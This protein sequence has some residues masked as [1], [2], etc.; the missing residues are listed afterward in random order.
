MG[1]AAR[2][3]LLGGFLL[4]AVGFSA[5]SVEAIIIRHDREDRTHHADPADFPFLA[6]V[7]V[8][9]GTLIA[10]DW[11]LT[12]AHVANG[13]SPVSGVVMVRGKT[14]NVLRIVYHPSWV[15]DLPEGFAEPSWVDLALLQLAEPISDVEPVALY[16]GKDEKGRTVT[17]VGRGKT[18]DGRGGPHR[19]DR[20]LR[21]AENEVTKAE[22][23]LLYFRFNRP[24]EGLNR[25]GIGG[26]GD[27]G[28]PALTRT[29]DKLFIVGVCFRNDGQGRGDAEF[30][31]GTH[32]VYTRVSTNMDWIREVMGTGRRGPDWQNLDRDPMPGHDAAAAATAFFEA[33]KRGNRDGFIAFENR[34]RTKEGLYALSAETRADTWMRQASRW[35][36]LTPQRWLQVTPGR[37]VV[38]AESNGQ[39]RSLSFEMQGPAPRKVREIHIAR[40]SSPAD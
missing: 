31:Y 35:K 9:H 11:I 26:P 12:A 37:F 18:G 13:V 30:K 24:P 39:W 40:E 5:S 3:A 23:H 27:S 20:V 29:D 28:G 8:A 25:E 1:S 16:D 34:W 33:F 10:P 22:D 6:D 14:V 36:S 2:R 32:D 4:G 19:E 7:G 21:S 17:F 38:L 15:G